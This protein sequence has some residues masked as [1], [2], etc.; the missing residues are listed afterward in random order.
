MAKLTIIYYSRTAHVY[1]SGAGRS[2]V[3]AYLCNLGIKQFLPLIEDIEVKYLHWQDA[4]Q[5]AEQTFELSTCFG[6]NQEEYDAETAHIINEI[7]ERITRLQKRGMSLR[8]LREALLS[9]QTPSRLIVT[10]DCH[11]ILADFN[12]LEI[13]LTPLCK[14]IYLLFLRHPEGILLKQMENHRDE[15]LMLYEKCAPTLNPTRRTNYVS[16]IVNP[17]HNSLNEKI[18][19]IHRCLSRLLDDNLLPFYIIDGRK[20]ETHRIRIASTLVEYC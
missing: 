13:P 16:T 10:T 3:H 17:L 11:L 12:N 4:Q 1:V 8:T 14:A 7:H 6:E 2:R 15:L 5:V 19:L 9:R 20:G 18:S